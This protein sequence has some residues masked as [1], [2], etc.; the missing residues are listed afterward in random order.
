M[1]AEMSLDS[2]RAVGLGVYAAY[3]VEA[4]STRPEQFILVHLRH[5][6]MSAPI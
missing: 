6:L 5:S 2:N 3:G 1:N 4:A